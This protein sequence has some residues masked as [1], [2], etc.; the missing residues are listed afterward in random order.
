MLALMV[1]TA[2]AVF[3]P[4][5]AIA[6]DAKA[7]ATNDMA[8]GGSRFYCTVSFTGGLAPYSI[9]WYKNGGL[10]SIFNDRTW[11]SQTCAAGSWLTIR[12]LVTDSAASFDEATIGPFQCVGGP[13]P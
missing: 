3:A 7:P 10:V 6:G 4:A 8:N 9:R 13:Q 1:F 5:N 2:L 12:V 11:I